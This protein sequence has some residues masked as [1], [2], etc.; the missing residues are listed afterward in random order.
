VAPL[1][2]RLLLDSAPYRYRA[3]LSD[4]A[5]LDPNIHHGQVNAAIGAVRGFL[6]AKSQRADLPGPIP[7]RNDTLRSLQSY[8][9]RLNR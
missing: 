5:G 7:W 9:F 3:S 4:A 8:L 2:H 6:V 1:L